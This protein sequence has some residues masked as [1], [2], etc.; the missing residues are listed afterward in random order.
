MTGVGQ[1]VLGFKYKSAKVPHRIG[2]EEMLGLEEREPIPPF[3]KVLNGYVA[4]R[5]LVTMKV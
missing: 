5:S 1:G 4:S 2:I 3:L